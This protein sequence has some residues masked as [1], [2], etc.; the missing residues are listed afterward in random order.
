AA[1][2]ADDLRRYS[3]GMP[4]LARA[5]GVAERFAGLIKRWPVVSALVAGVIALSAMLIAALMVTA[6]QHRQM[7]VAALVASIATPDSQ[8]L[9][10]LL[11]R[12][13]SQQPVVLPLIR[14]AL[15][16]SKAGE[17]RWVNLTVAELTADPSASGDALLKYL[18]SASPGEVPAIVGVLRPR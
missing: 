16:E 17:T 6:H 2:L 14:A 11:G 5:P 15:S 1:A 13:P 18:P 12:V 3:D 10:Q 9:P 4:I 7:A 8:S